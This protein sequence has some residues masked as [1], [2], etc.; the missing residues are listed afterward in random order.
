MVRPTGPTGWVSLEKRR[1]RR[2][3][4]TLYN[5]L[6]GGGSEVGVSLCSHVMETG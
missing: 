2:D 4:T 3:P 6:K 5:S 1:I